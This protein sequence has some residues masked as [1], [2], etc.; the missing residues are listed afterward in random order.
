MGDELKSE[1]E[2]QELY[3][4]T[5]PKDTTLSLGTLHDDNRA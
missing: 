1:T 4:D 5:L 2:E 3:L